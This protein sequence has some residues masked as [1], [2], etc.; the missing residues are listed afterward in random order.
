MKKTISRPGSRLCRG[1]T[2]VAVAARYTAAYS[3]I[4]RLTGE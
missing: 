3:R 2:E 1:V 4:Y